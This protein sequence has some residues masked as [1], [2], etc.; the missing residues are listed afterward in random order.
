MS[1]PGKETQPSRQPHPT[2]KPKAPE[3]KPEA[4]KLKKEPTKPKSSELAP[5]Q[6]AVL[7]KI[8]QERFQGKTTPWAEMVK[9]VSDELWVSRKVI[10]QRLRSLDQPDIP[11]TPELT[12]QII[13]RY[14]Y[15]VEH[16]E[17]PP[18]GRRKKISAELKIPFSQVRNILYEWSVNQFKQS[19]TPDLSRELRF[20]IE[21]RYTSELEARHVPLDDIP[22]KLAEEMGNVTSYQISRWLDMLH[23][24][25]ARFAHIA[26]IPSETEQAIIDAY[27]R[28]LTS[29]APPQEGLHGT[30]ADAIGGV[31]RRQVHKTLQKY[32]NQRRAE[33]P[34][35]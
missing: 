4:P 8:Y 28:Y 10:S 9:A 19:P 31:T 22:K 33:Y 29:P 23:D 14:K 32:R 35:L 26:E 13:E 18:E 11:I 24:D 1:A 27:R 17:R 34:S 25:D 15:Y 5:E 20:E 3:R 7:E 12:A 2:S 21:K 6:E 16:G 30:I